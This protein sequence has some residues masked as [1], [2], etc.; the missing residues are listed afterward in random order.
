MHFF[1]QLTWVEPDVAI[2]S[3]EV[4]GAMGHSLLDRVGEEDHPTCERPVAESAAP[5]SAV[6]LSVVER[7]G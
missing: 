1:A 2:G 4:T 3:D 6:E 7:E 5:R